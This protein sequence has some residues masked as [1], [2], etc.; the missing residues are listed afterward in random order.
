MNRYRVDFHVHTDASGDGR[1]SLQ[2]LTRSAQQAGLHAIAVTDHNRC[3]PVPPVLNGVLLI[4]ACEV[5]TQCGHILGLFLQRDISF[6]RNAPLP[7][8][9]EAVAAI[10][11]AG[12]LAVLAHPF[13]QPER[14]ASDLPRDV[15]GVEACNARGNLKR[16]D[17][18]ALAAAFAEDL[19]VFVTGGSDA[20]HAAETGYAFTEIDAE[21]L[22]LDALR[23]ALL[24]KHSRAVLVRETSYTQKALSQWKHAKTKSLSRRVKGLLYLARGVSR[25]FIKKVRR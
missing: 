10:R 19:D 12:G 8:G 3:T 2:A 7:T 17:A 13:Q 16:A 14:K 24:A 9:E 6:S 20:H 22:T 5:S 21:E 25:D 4:P 23:A 11:A 1:S 18:N 15:D